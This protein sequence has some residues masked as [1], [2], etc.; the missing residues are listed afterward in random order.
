VLCTFFQVDVDF[1][2]PTGIWWFG[3]SASN[4]EVEGSNTEDQFINVDKNT[5]NPWRGNDNS[6]ASLTTTSMIYSILFASI[7][8]LVKLL[9]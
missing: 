3:C 5:V 6:G 1:P 4:L 2:R 9:P 8:T 7:L